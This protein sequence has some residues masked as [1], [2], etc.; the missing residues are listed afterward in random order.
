MAGIQAFHRHTRRSGERMNPWSSER[1]M[2]LRHPSS[3]DRATDLARRLDMASRRRTA[4][5][6]TTPAPNTWHS[7]RP[8][9]GAPRDAAGRR[10]CGAREAYPRV[11]QFRFLPRCDSPQVNL[12]GLRVEGGR[13]RRSSAF[14]RRRVP[15]E[16]GAAE[17]SLR[18]PARRCRGDPGC[19][20]RA[21]ARAACVAGCA[22]I[23]HEGGVCSR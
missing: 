17:A 20:S 2:Q 10:A 16:P 3:L 11:R 4:G 19:D 7:R 13:P 18:P 5:M 8:S 1:E 22:P 12:A 9:C 21:M 14:C 23:P 15:G 6:A